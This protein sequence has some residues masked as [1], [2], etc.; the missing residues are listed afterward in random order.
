MSTN[1]LFEITSLLREDGE[2]FEFGCN[3]DEVERLKRIS[4]DRYPDRRYRVVKNWVLWDLDG[5]DESKS[6]YNERG[7]QPT[8]L[9]AKNVVF[10]SSRKLD[11]GDFARSTPLQKLDEG[12]F[13]VTANTVY[14]CLGPGTRKTV[15]PQLVKAVYFGY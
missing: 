11:V 8:M 14:I 1:K 15:A 6:I 10:D 7:F 12:C 13:F 5:D 4:V 9:Y 2:P 3:E